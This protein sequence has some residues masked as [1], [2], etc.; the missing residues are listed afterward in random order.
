MNHHRCYRSHVGL[1]VHVTWPSI[2]RHTLT[3]AVTVAA[4]TSHFHTSTPRESR[5]H[6]T[7]HYERLGISQNA[8]KK[9][10]KSQFYKL[11]KLHHP[12]KNDT[13]DSRRTFLSINEAYSVLG[14]ERQRRD[15]DLTLLDKTGSLYSNS[16]SQRAQ[17]TRGTLRRTPF[18]HSPQSAAAADAA[19]AAAARRAHGAFGTHF[20]R[21]TGS[22]PHFDAKSHQEMHYEQDV[23]REERRQARERADAEY[24]R[25]QGYDDSDSASGR[26]FRVTLVLLSIMLATSFMKV[27]ADEGADD[28]WDRRQQFYRSGHR[29]RD[30]H[31]QRDIDR[32]D[33][34][35]QSRTTTSSQSK[36]L[37]ALWDAD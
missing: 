8:T 31:S 7:N 14:N 35:L 11:S 22:V 30:V 36:I 25:K 9:E 19:A 1:L 24:R 3:A 37:S 4:S 32:H 15:Y 10:I 17:P 13:E 34:D 12:D 21:Q 16:S 23:R 27:S 2:P 26:F 28:D 33:D 29:Q 6:S 20:G 18:R 5:S